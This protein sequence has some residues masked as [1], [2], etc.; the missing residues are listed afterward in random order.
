[1]CPREGFGALQKVS[2]K[3]DILPG[4]IGIRTKAWGDPVGVKKGL[5]TPEGQKAEHGLSRKVGEAL[6]EP[7]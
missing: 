7:E 4:G 6:G 5:W 3:Q 2:E 1:M